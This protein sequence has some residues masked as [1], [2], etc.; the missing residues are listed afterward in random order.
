M[1]LLDSLEAEGIIMSNNNHKNLTKRILNI[2]N[3]RRW[4]S[5]TSD[6]TIVKERKKQCKTESEALAKK[7]VE[8]MNLAI[9]PKFQRQHIGKIRANKSFVVIDFD[10]PYTE[11]QLFCIL[12]QISDEVIYKFYCEFCK[13]AKSKK[14]DENLFFKVIETITEVR[15]LPN[16]AQPMDVIVFNNNY[17]FCSYDRNYN[18]WEERAYIFRKPV[19][20][21]TCS[22][23][24]TSHEV[25]IGEQ[26]ECFCGTAI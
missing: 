2:L 6:L 18:F 17:D 19:E 7:L 13:I 3:A 8:Q 24:G 15:G 22:R 21:R 12:A 11:E 9:V 20:D 14:P 25:S 5:P 23:C 1:L 10:K 16:Q 26:H 4:V